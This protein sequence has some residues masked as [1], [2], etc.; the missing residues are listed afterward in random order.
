MIPRLEELTWKEAE[1]RQDSLVVLPTGSVEQ[2]GLHLPLVVDTFLVTRVAEEAIRLADG[3]GE[4]L[5]CPTLPYG[6]SEAHVDFCGTISIGPE[7]YVALITELVGSL[8]DN[9]FRRFLLLNGHGG[10]LDLLKTAVRKIRRR[11]DGTLVTVSSY[12][13]IASASIQEWRK[14]GPGGVCHACEMETSL[15][16]FLAPELVRTDAI[17]D[18]IPQWVS[19]SIVDDLQ[20]GGRTLPGVRVKD[21][22]ATG[23]LGSPSLASTERGE[24]LFGRITRDVSSFLQDMSRWS[25]EGIVQE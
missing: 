22:S 16:L 20:H 8:A 10:N 21:V 1:E 25:L 19:D 17:S 18:F 24:D 4:V 9:G 14:S 11:E 23:T 2:H 15:M 13:Q 3:S 5:L 6:F 7:T 12:W